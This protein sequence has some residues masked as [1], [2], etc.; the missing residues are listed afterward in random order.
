[1]TEEA[2]ETQS[3][4]RVDEA[5][6]AEDSHVV[7][8]RGHVEPAQRIWFQD[9]GQPMFGPG[10]L[11]LLVLITQTGSLLQAAK[12]M[13]MAYSKAW[14]IVREAENHLGVQLI[15]RHAGGSGGGGSALTPDGQR[16]MVKFVA[17]RAEAETNLQ[18]L[19]EKY[20][21]DEPFAARPDPDE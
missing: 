20:F 1:M 8:G 5:Q 6:P 10:T 9:A 15:E 18:R 19:Y 21:G 11:K 12:K 16:L 17:M 7:A 3:A 13:G 4:G 2:P 14:R